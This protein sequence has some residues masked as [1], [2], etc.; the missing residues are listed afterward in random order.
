MIVRPNDGWRERSHEALGGVHW[1]VHGLQPS[2]VRSLERATAC[3][4]LSLN[5]RCSKGGASSGNIWPLLTSDSCCHWFQINGLE[6]HYPPSITEPALGWSRWDL[7]PL[8]SKHPSGHLLRPALLAH[9]VIGPAL[10]GAGEVLAVGDHALVQLAGEHR[11]ATTGQIAE[12]LGLLLAVGG[13]AAQV[14]DHPAG[15]IG[16]GSQRCLVAFLCQEGRFQ[17]SQG[18]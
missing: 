5:R 13:L 3:S 8:L 12:A 17:F 18:Q 6:V 7:L 14:F 9:Q 15:G 2:A 10:A 16:L 1:G 4:R 11:D